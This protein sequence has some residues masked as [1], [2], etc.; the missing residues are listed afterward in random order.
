MSKVYRLI[1]I[2]S[3]VLFVFV[4]AIPAYA[5]DSDDYSLYMPSIRAATG[6]PVLDE[7]DIT[8]EVAATSEQLSTPFGV[9]MPWQAKE[10]SSS[11]SDYYRRTFNVLK[12]TATSGTYNGTVYKPWWYDW[13][14]DGASWTGA[15]WWKLQYV[16]MLWG[17]STDWGPSGCT[18]GDCD[19]DGYGDYY[20]E[21]KDLLYEQYLVDQEEKVVLL[22]NEP[23]QQAG[24]DYEDFSGMLADLYE[25][26]YAPAYQNYGLEPKWIGPNISVAAAINDSTFIAGVI[27]EI[28]WLGGGCLWY[29]TLPWCLDTY[30]APL[31]LYSPLHWGIHIYDTTTTGM[32]NQLDWWE[33]FLADQIDE[34]TFLDAPETAWITEFASLS[35]DWNVQKA[36]VSWGYDAISDTSHDVDKAFWFGAD[37]HEV[38]GWSIDP[39]NDLVQQNETTLTGR[40]TRFVSEFLD[41]ANTH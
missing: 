10:Y 1:A 26:V 12:T 36:T 20:K 40:G 13:Q 3:V 17:C 24:I 23:T 8:L 15:L 29:G 6:D 41:W 18:N 30:Y 31:S 39:Y 28:D 11:P 16:P 25:D 4:V 22:C 21:F 14:P 5:Q 34:S 7:L 35:Y 32:E 27:D 38:P 37:T 2:L 33:G 9:G 19:S